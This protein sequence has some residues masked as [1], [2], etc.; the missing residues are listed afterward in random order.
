M[1]CNCAEPFVGLSIAG[2]YAGNASL[3]F[4]TLLNTLIRDKC[5]VSQI[6]ERV[7]PKTEPDD[8]YDFIVVGGGSTGSVVAA[9]LAEVPNWK[10]LVLEA[11]DDEPVGSQVPS[12]LSNFIG[13]PRMGWVYKLE[14]E[15]EACLGNEGGV[16]S[17]PRARVL[18]GCGVIN[19][20]MY[21]RG[22]KTDYDNWAAAGNPGWSYEDLLPFF[23]KSENNQQIGELVDQTYH[24][25]G[26]PMN[27]EQ[28]HNQPET[29]PDILKAAEE[30]G[31]PVSNDLNGKDFV[32]FAVA[33][34]ATKYL[35]NIATPN[36]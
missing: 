11:G 8:S 10:V 21:A 15:P 1:A 22:T 18:G 34:A 29:A 9:R 36:C 23:F 30:M 14:P 31:Y 12:L 13:D 26:G 19:G 2:T 32:G 20:M 28:F 5:D 25:T 16:C 6:C 4:M 3:L 17:W 7:S 27:I 35:I 33:Q 24:A